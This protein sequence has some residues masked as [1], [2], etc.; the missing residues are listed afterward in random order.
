LASS[1][2]LVQFLYEKKIISHEKTSL[3]FFKVL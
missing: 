2:L 3:I 1:Y